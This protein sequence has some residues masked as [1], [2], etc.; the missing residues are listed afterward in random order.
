[1]ESDQQRVKSRESEFPPTEEDEESRPGGRSYKETISNQQSVRTCDESHYYKQE[2]ERH[3]GGCL[4]FKSVGNRCSFLQI[5][6]VTHDRRDRV[7]A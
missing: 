5:F 4:L 6:R 2:S 3:D 7:D 1:M